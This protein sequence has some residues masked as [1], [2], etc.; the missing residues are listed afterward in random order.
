MR[1]DNLF[2]QL[3]AINDRPL[4]AELAHRAAQIRAHKTHAGKPDTETKRMAIE[5][6]Y[7]AMLHVFA[8]L[9]GMSRDELIRHRGLNNRPD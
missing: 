4:A 7:Q 3:A 9:G 8:A 6:D 5:A 1:Y 2:E